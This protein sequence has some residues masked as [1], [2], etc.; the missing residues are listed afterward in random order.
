MA[1][2]VVGCSSSG[3]LPEA[4]NEADNTS[5]K[6]HA[7]VVS[8][9]A[10]VPSQ[11]PAAGAYRV[12]MIDV[13]SGLSMLVQ[14]HDF[15]ALFDGGSGDDSRGIT[16][17]GNKSR[18]LSYLFAALGPSGPPECT[19]EGDTWPTR[20][21]AEKTIDHLFLSH[22]HDDHVAMLDAVLHCYKVKN[23]WEPGFGYDN[24][25]YGAFLTEVS[26]EA[27]VHYHTYVDVPADRS[28][29]VNG[30][31]ITIPRSSTWTT[32]GENDVQALGA[33]ARFKVLHAD[34]TPHA[35]DANLNSLVLRVEL[36]KT[37][38]LLAGDEMAGARAAPESSPGATQA[39]GLLLTKHAK[40]IDVDILQVPHHGSS[41][42]SR[43]EFLKAVSPQWALLSAGPLP[44]AGQVLPDKPVVDALTSLVPNLLRTD[45]HDHG[46]CAT[47]DRIG[48]E[49]SAPGGCDNHVLDILP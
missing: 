33:G 40:D 25:N 19:P 27:G 9:V 12:T 5:G 2:V 32:F 45:S 24:I 10:D 41:T 26:T 42:S 6:V 44:Y 49:D 16:M 13:G 11:P 20:S 34:A 37:S 29:R 46:T 4:G 39:E 23:V 22:P 43:L 36:G 8:A 21:G 3:A 30:T 38:L 7:R 14:G 47:K 15:N 48:V 35:Q 1:A 31:K 28:Q 18:L 17:S